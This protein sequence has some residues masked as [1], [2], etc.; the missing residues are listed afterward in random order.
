MSIVFTS[1]SPLLLA[2]PTLPTSFTLSNSWPP[3]LQLLLSHTHIYT[4]TCAY[5]HTHTYAH[6]LLSSFSVA[7]VC[8]CLGMS[9]WVCIAYLGE[10]SLKKNEFSFTWKLLFAFISSSMGGLCEISPTHTGMPT[11]GLIDR[12][13]LSDTIVE[14]LLG[15]LLCHI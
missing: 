15:K 12:S 4:C 6:K 5:M 11:G 14:I 7:Y 3:L 1:F 9:T 13:C 10:M 2:P 8:M